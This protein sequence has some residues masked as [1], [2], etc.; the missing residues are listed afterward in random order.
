[1]EMVHVKAT[2]MDTFRSTHCCI[3][4][5]CDPR[6]ITGFDHIKMKD[7]GDKLN[8]EMAEWEQLFPSFKLTRAF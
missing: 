3:P 6:H 4:Q 1:M 2:I 5:C 7:N 8:R